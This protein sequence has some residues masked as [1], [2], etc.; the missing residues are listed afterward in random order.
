MTVF[1]RSY[2]RQIGAISL[3]T[4][5]GTSGSRMRSASARRRSWSGRTYEKSRLIATAM[6]SGAPS[7]RCATSAT[8]RSISSSSSGTRTSPSKATRSRT[9]MQSGRAT[10]GLGFTHWMSKS[11]LRLMRWMNGTSSKPFVVRKTTRWPLR[12]SRQFVA[13]VV[14]RT[15]RPTSSGATPLRVNASKTAAAGCAG[16]EGTFTVLCRPSASSTTTRSVKVPPV[17]TPMRTG[18]SGTQGSVD[19][20][21]GSGQVRRRVQREVAYE[22]R[23]LGGRRVASD[24]DRAGE[25]GLDAGDRLQALL[26]PLH[27]R[28]VDAAGT[29]GVGGDAEAGHLARERPRQTHERMLRGAVR[30]RVLGAGEPGARR[31]VD[32]APPPPLLEVRQDRFQQAERAEDV[33]VVE[34]DQLVRRDVFERRDRALHARRVDDRI[35]GAERVERTRDECAHLPLIAEV[36]PDGQAPVHPLERSSIRVREHERRV[37]LPKRLHDRRADP[38]CGACDED[39][40]HSPAASRPNCAVRPPSTS[41]TA[42]VTNDARSEQRNA[43]AAATS[44]ASPTRPSAC[45]RAIHSCRACGWLVSNMSLLMKPGARQ[46][47]RTPSSARSSA[48]C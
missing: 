3:D 7:E 25:G 31:D 35:H 18:R 15:N 34:L 20:E 36:G 21:C 27:H 22:P 14:P 10:Y 8:T 4:E 17:S 26:D 28:R 48:V 23:H 33:D 38:A 46:L 30:S 37:A 44:S 16:V 39:D 9:P 47:T 1:A 32:D 24:G 42:P 19:Y 41:S 5:S 6:P 12:S 40:A 29:H 11:D 13:T 43:T 2:S 45:R